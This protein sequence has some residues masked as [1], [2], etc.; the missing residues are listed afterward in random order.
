VMAEQD[1]EL[2]I[3]QRDEEKQKRSDKLRELTE[4]QIA[5]YKEKKK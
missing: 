4:D 5:V 1:V 2:A 3:R